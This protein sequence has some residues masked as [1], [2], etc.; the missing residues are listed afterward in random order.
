[1]YDIFT[2]FFS[3]SNLSNRHRE[4]MS[5]NSIEPS[6]G[7]A[8]RTNVEKTNKQIKMWYTGRKSSSSYHISWLGDL[9]AVVP[10]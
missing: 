10:Q 1:M 5:R 8:V 3:F 9:T 7:L 6:W 2:A 4:N